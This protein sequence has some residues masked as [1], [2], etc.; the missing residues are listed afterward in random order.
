MVA[1]QNQLWPSTDEIEAAI[2]GIN[3]SDEWYTPSDLVEAVR[4]FMGG[5]DIDPASCDVAQRVVR[6]S[7]YYTIAD[8]GLTKDWHG[9]LWL[10]PP[11]SFPLVRNF[12]GRAL[13]QYGYSVTQ[14]FILVNNVTE[15][16]WFQLLLSRHPVCFI[17][18][19]VE[20]WRPDREQVVSNDGSRARR[21][22][23]LFYMGSESDRFELVFRR[24]GTVV[25]SPTLKA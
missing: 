3:D 20:F 10:N 5:I 4:E 6:A 7:T 13:V 17:R 8:D 19:R 11:Y 22:Q 23:A 16:S 14:G 9:R 12:T 18:G 15:A 25:A 21:G 2:N 1:I 24:F